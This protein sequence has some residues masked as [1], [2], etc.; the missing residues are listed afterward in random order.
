VMTAISPDTT[1]EKV[2]ALTGVPFKTAAAVATY[3]N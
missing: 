1:V 3:A 2:K